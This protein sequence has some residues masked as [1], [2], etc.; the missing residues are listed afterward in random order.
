[1]HTENTDSDSEKVKINF[2]K[3]KLG[4]MLKMRNESV[5]DHKKNLLESIFSKNFAWYKNLD[6]SPDKKAHYKQDEYSPGF[7]NLIGRQSSSSFKGAMKTN[8]VYSSAKV[9]VDKPILKRQGSILR[10]EK[11]E[12]DSPGF[13]EYG[14]HSPAKDKKL[15]RSGSETST[16][17]LVESKTA[18]RWI[19]YNEK[20]DRTVK[21]KLKMEMKRNQLRDQMGKIWIFSNFIGIVTRDHKAIKLHK[22]RLHK[23]SR[24]GSQDGISSPNAVNDHNQTYDA[25]LM[26]LKNKWKN[27]LGPSSPND[28]GMVH[29]VSQDN[30]NFSNYKKKEIKEE[31]PYFKK[32]KREDKIAKILQ[33]TEDR[34]RLNGG[35]KDRYWYISD[36]K[37]FLKVDKF[38]VLEA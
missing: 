31:L 6:E 28:H 29:N 4:K 36:P 26:N 8:H 24:I 7:K 13:E 1:M 32:T 16:R 18:L 10:P 34:I 30:I 19:R 9:S 25:A 38:N 14:Y 33:D 35:K 17:A 2:T 27:E 22:N 5:S 15:S 20:D 11:I 23:R 21:L 3:E 37:E 12:D